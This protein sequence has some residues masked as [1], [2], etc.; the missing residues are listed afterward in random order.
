[1][2]VTMTTNDRPLGDVKVKTVCIVRFASPLAATDAHPGVFYQVT[3]DPRAFSPS[4]EF[5]RF[6]LFHGDELIGWQP[7]SWVTVCEEL[8]EW[9]GETFP[10]IPYSGGITM[11]A[12]G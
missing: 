8:V 11:I 7:A 9:D 4:G 3:V 2:T 1:M 12:K 5:Y 6:G 10:Q